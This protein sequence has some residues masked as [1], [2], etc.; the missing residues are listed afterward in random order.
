MPQNPFEIILNKIDYAHSTPTSSTARPLQNAD[1]SN[2]Q[3]L[4]HRARKLEDPMRRIMTA[5]ALSTLFALSAPAFAKP[6]VA[7]RSTPVVAGDT[8]PAEG[9]EAKP[10]EAK[11][12]P[13]KSSKKTKKT[14]KTEAAPAP[15]EGAP[16]K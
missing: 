7:K 12:A 11:P 16:A 2:H 14:E 4:A 1:A 15:A 9:G 10:A 5:A 8:K 13:K 6:V 3:P